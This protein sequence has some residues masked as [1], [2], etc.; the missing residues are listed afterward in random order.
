MEMVTESVPYIGGASSFYLSCYPVSERFGFRLVQSRKATAAARITADRNCQSDCL[1][2]NLMGDARLI[3]Q[4]R[5]PYRTDT[6]PVAG[7]WLSLS[8]L[9]RLPRMRGAWPAPV[10]CGPFVMSE[11]AAAGTRVGRAEAA[12]DRSTPLASIRKQALGGLD[13]QA[14]GL[15]RQA[16]RAAMIRR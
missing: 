14:S 15:G 16:Q 2:S 6:G 3:E 5:R 4:F 11:S 1:A 10:L 7:R 12:T 9:P 8:P 13:R